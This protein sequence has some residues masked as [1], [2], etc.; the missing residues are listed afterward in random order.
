MA[1]SNLLIYCFRFYLFL[2]RREGRE[3]NIDQLALTRPQLGTWSATQEC[4][5]TGTQTRDLLVRRPAFNPLSHTSQGFANILLRIFAFVFVKDFCLWCQ[6]YAGL[7]QVVNYSLVDWKSWQILYRIGVIY[8][9][10]LKILFLYFWREGTGG[11]RG[12]KDTPV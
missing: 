5:L 12:G 10:V 4:V 7:R 9:F 2:E 1:W 8:F 3:R 11:S 6:G